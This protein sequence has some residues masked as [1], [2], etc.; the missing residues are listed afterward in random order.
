MVKFLARFLSPPRVILAR[1][2]LR[3]GMVGFVGFLFDAGTVYA[4]KALVGLYI[5]GILAYVVAATVT[6]WLN[7]RWTFQG[8]GGGGSVIRQWAIFM[9]ANF[10][11]FIVNRGIYML[12]VTFSAVCA[13]HPIFAVMGGIPA[14]MLFNFNLSRR[15]VFRT[16]GR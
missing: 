11:G 6:W 9:S 13:A 7:R 14:G 4:S 2:F 8:L 5:A 15:V 16:T 12:L 1:Q 3:F 10:V